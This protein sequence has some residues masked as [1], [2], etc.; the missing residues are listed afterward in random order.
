MCMWKGG[1]FSPLPPTE[2]K[3]CHAPPLPP[4]P[5]DDQLSAAALAF[6]G[7]VMQT[8]PMFS[9]LKVDGVKLCNLAR[10]G[11]SVE[12]YRGAGWGRGGGGGRV[13]LCN[14]AR[15]AACALGR[16]LGEQGLGF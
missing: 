8:P 10:A 4:P 11:K 13:R 7:D 2:L 5:S 9:A 12:R 16:G 3:V 14:L 6:T 1:T 15:A